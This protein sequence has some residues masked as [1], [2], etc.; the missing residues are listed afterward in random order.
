MIPT[1][2]YSIEK[3]GVSKNNVLSMAYAKICKKGHF[4]KIPFHAKSEFMNLEAKHH[5]NNH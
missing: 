5:R 1:Y 3:D 4:S 2:T